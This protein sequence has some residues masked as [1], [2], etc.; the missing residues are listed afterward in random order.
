MLDRPRVKFMRR[1]EGTVSGSLVR[2][3]LLVLLLASRPATASDE[4]VW[5]GHGVPADRPTW[6]HRDG[7]RIGLAPAPGPQG[8]IRIYAPYL[9]QQYPRMVNFLS[10]E[11]A[12][13]GLPGRGQSELEQSRQHPGQSGL[14]FTPANQVLKVTAADELPSGIL[15][16]QAGTLTL[17]VH[18]E[19]FR[20]GA[21][22]ILE[23]IFYRGRPHEVEITIHAAPHSAPMESCVIS[24]TMGNYGML[25]ELH[26][27]DGQTARAADLWSDEQLDGLGF[28]PWRSWPAEKLG[29][30]GK[31]EY[32]VSLSSNF[33]QPAHAA[34]ATVVPPQWRYTGQGATHVWRTEAES[35]PTVAVNA[36]R[37][38][39]GTVAPIAGGVCFENFELRIPFQDRQRLWFGIAPGKSENTP[40][41][42]LN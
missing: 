22:P 4:F 8:L 31:G 15:D 26:L 2:G 40:D 1:P 25:R 30:T 6:G 35:A 9:R 27:A 11:P 24:A 16:P 34:Y 32:E 42:P 23:L 17:F 3:I 36:R 18:P 13:T 29:R 14:T 19:P 28:L 20:N 5:P 10:V 7:L 39:W 12:V 37:T 38:Y 21:H 33:E 41:S